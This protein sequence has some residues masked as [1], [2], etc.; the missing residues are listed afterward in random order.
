MMV[1]S[2]GELPTGVAVE[3]HLNFWVS[4]KLSEGSK[5]QNL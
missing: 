1:G 3:A 5:G 4:F 2:E